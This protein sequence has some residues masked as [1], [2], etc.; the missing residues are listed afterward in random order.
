[1]RGNRTR[2]ARALRSAQNVREPVRFAVRELSNRRR[3]SAYRLRGSPLRAVIRQPLIDAW[4]LDEIF[5]L[6]QYAL[7]GNVTA[8]L[9]SLGRAP[10]VLDLGG[11]VGL[12]GLSFRRWFP[13]ASF[14]SYEPD[15]DNVSVLRECVRVNRLDDR[16][17]V[18]E[19]AAASSDGNATFLSDYQLSQL[20]SN[21]D[22][23]HGEHELVAQVFPFMRGRQL[24]QAREV[25]VTTRD[26]FDDIAACDFLKMDI[27]GGEWDLFADPRFDNLSAAALVIEVHPRAAPVADVRGYVTR[28]LESL[29]FTLE[30][31]VPAHGGEL[32]VWASR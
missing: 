3:T 11:H 10:R 24:L 15:P 23:L 5:R 16:W 19:A 8:R 28:R 29:G 17:R 27:Q 14:T 18:V 20:G 6:G 13:D 21:A 9:R 25:T 12:F 31:I 26:A 4:V 22:D 7:P 1:M 30:P 32:I 2:I